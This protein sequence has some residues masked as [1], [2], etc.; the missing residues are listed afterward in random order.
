MSPNTYHTTEYIVTLLNTHNLPLTCQT[1]FGGVHGYQLLVV[2]VD[3][4]REV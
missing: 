1:S 4:N 3:Q 2:F